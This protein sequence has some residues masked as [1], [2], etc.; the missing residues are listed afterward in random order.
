MK[1]LM[2]FVLGALLFASQALAQVDV[3]YMRAGVANPNWRDPVASAGALP[4]SNNHV[5]DIRFSI[6]DLTLYG[7]DGSA[8]N[9]L[10]GGG[11]GGI[12]IGAPVIGGTPEEMLYIDAAGDLATDNL[13]T[14][15][16]NAKHNTEILS[17]TY[18]QAS[19][20]DNGVGTEYFLQADNF[21][22]NPTITFDGV[23]DTDTIVAAWNTANPSDTVSVISGGTNIPVAETVTLLGGGPAGVGSGTL[24]AFAPIEGVGLIASDTS[25]NTGTA[26]SVH[27]NL[28]PVVGTTTFGSIIGLTS[29]NGLSLGIFGENQSQVFSSDFTTYNS[30][31]NLNSEQSI[32]SF[33]NL[34][35]GIDTNDGGFVFRNSTDTVVIPNNFTTPNLGDILQVTASSGGVHTLDFVTPPSSSGIPNGTDPFQFWRWDDNAGTQDW[36]QVFILTEPASTD[37]NVIIGENAGALTE[38]SSAG[39]GNTIVGTGAA[40][41]LSSGTASEIS[42]NVVMGLNAAP[43]VALM[44]NSIVL[45]YQTFTGGTDQIIQSIIMTPDT[46]GASTGQPIT[47]SIAIGYGAK[48]HG[49]NNI[50]IGQSAASNISD[51]AEDSV[52]VGSAAATSGNNFYR[53]VAIGA[54]AG[55]GYTSG[56]RNT[57]IGF[58]TSSGGVTSQSIAL[59]NQAQV[60][61]NHQMTIGGIAGTVPDGAI[62]DIRFN[63]G[64]TDLGGEKYSFKYPDVLTSTT[65]GAGNE[66]EFYAGRGTGNAAGS[67]FSF[68]VSLPT[69]SGTTQHGN[70]KS[71]S[72]SGAVATLGD[73]SNSNNKNKIIV[74]NKD[75]YIYVLTSDVFDVFDNNNTRYLRI[76]YTN[77]LAGIG[78]VDGADNGSYVF[79]KDADESVELKANETIEITDAVIRGNALHNNALSQGSASEQD[80]RSGTWTA[81]ATN[82]T[83]IASITVR[84]GQW[85]RVGNVVNF[86][87][88][89]EYTPS[90]AGA[91]SFEFSLPVASNLTQTYQV[92]G[93][94]IGVSSGVLD[95]AAWVNGSVTNNTAV[96]TGTA[97]NTNTH[98]HYITGTYVVL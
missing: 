32:L 84:E 54:S 51:S 88:A 10:T 6:G 49:T 58:G 96:H 64:V 93:T 17:L 68:F 23:S 55:S 72:L 65:N 59:G 94:S 79:V 2:S 90:G 11:G 41:S 24:N 13:A 61:A 73:V 22:S 67:E 81:T 42:R 69:T 80:I 70:F 7:W 43:V 89:V 37:A 15:E 95:D 35:I 12:S 9:A 30:A 4:S 92:S 33:N 75:Q 31:V 45:G 5:G 39:Y 27:G 40:Q 21:G 19:N 53:D 56:G 98:T 83:N 87:L 14:R 18:A 85:L 29:N 36:N 60:N 28:S 48:I 38:A 97:I 16:S 66:V 76:D 47:N 52:I 25:P 86:S 91:T 78:D 74:N 82:T 77:A 3:D 46:T 50:V 34:S 71:L 26:I 44:E 20:Q 8:W 62:Y 1:L 57:F 63:N